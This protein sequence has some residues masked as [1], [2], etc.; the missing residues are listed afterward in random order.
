MNPATDLGSDVSVMRAYADLGGVCAQTD[1]EAWFP[2]KGGS[3][4]AAKQI[5]WACPER[6]GC[7]KTSLD[8][9]ERFGV[10]AGLSERDR[11]ALL[12]TWKNATP[13][14]KA[15]LLDEWMQIRAERAL[16]ALVK[17]YRSVN[18]AAAKKAKAAAEAAEKNDTTTG[19]LAA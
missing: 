6:R 16:T 13:A 10:W 18:A 11:R 1:P 3:T 12:P 2:E 5:C 4:R 17:Y 9:G 8:I 15:K 7:M 14:G 19:Q